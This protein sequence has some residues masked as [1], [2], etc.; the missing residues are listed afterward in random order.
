MEMAK[1]IQDKL[2]G[3]LRVCRILVNIYQAVACASKDFLP[4]GVYYLVFTIPHE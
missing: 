4:C 1:G 3:L 2:G